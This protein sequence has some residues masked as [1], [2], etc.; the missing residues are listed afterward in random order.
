MGSKPTSPSSLAGWFSFVVRD[1]YFYSCSCD[2]T[3]G[4]STFNVKCVEASGPGTRGLS[5]QADGQ[6]AGD[7]PIGFCAA[8][9]DTVDRLVAG[10]VH[11]AANRLRVREVVEVGG[12]VDLDHLV[13]WRPENTWS[14]REGI[15]SRWCGIDDRDCLGAA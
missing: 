9:A 11:D 7:F 10:D 14:D 8:I 13:A 15:Y 1:G 5:P 3:T 6:V 12:N 2:I 4:V